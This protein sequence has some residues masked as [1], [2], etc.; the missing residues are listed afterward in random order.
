MVA[1]DAV[2]GS[3]VG[4]PGRFAQFS[5]STT[6][7]LAVT[8]TRGGIAGQLTWFDRAGKASSSI[9]QPPGVEYLNPAI[10]PD[11]SRMAANRM[12]PVTGNWDIWVLD[13]ARNI[14]S[15]LTS[16]PASDGDPVWSSDGKEIVFASNRGG[17]FGVYRK[18]VDGSGS[19]ERLATIDGRFTGLALSDWSPDGRYV[20][21]NVGTSP[22]HQWDLWA[23]PLFGDRRPFPVMPGGFSPPGAR[24]SPDGKWI[25]YSSLETGWYEVYVQRFMAAGDKKQVSRGSG[26][27][28][29]WTSDGRELMYWDA[30]RGV[31]SVDID[32]YGTSL[33]VGAPK[34]LISTPIL[35]LIDGRPHYDVTRDGRRFLLRRPAGAQRPAITVMVNWT[36]KLKK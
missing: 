13:V 12:D 36:E 27:H 19:E 3:L 11:G 4:P 31:E 26:A 2:P 15:R 29:R 24:F 32:I 14:A 30:P 10:S 33:R 20:L 34:T 28:P 21:Y 18:A 5:A 9:E 23:L 8:K 17:E 16:D 6:G 25:A 7:V 1:Q 22:V 35:P